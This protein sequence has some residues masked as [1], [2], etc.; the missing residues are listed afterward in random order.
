MT[1]RNFMTF[2]HI[3]DEDILVEYATFIR[4]DTAAAGFRQLVDMTWDRN[5][6]HASKRITFY[7]TVASVRMQGMIFNNQLVHSSTAISSVTPP[8]TS[9]TDPAAVVTPALKRSRVSPKITYSPATLAKYSKAI[10][11]KVISMLAIDIPSN[12]SLRDQ[13]LRKVI[14]RLESRFNDTEDKR[15]TN[16]VIIANIKELIASTNKFGRNDR[17]SIQF[18]ENLALAVTSNLSLVKLMVATGLSSR[19]LQQ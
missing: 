14:S 5:S 6:S 1:V 7:I 8:I 11:N 12:D 2:G 13:V 16:E 19:V 15:N 17:E 18:K 9:G 10:E 3:V 4:K